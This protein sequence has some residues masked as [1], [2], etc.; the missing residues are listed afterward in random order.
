MSN[1]FM[2]GTVIGV[3]AVLLLAAIGYRIRGMRLSQQPGFGSIVWL[4]VILT[5][6]TLLRRFGQSD[7]AGLVIA[8][9]IGWWIAY[10]FGQMQETLRMLRRDTVQLEERLRHYDEMTS[11][12]TIRVSKT[13]DGRVVA[14]RWT[15]K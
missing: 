5:T 2:D 3:W 8:A 11:G 15:V 6:S 12:K 1:S 7:F 10:K 13:D 14:E 4:A 9:G